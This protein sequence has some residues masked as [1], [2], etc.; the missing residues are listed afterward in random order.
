ME[1]KFL[2]WLFQKLKCQRG[3][4]AEDLNAEDIQ[5]GTFMADID[6]DEY[7]IDQ[8]ENDDKHP[9]EDEADDEKPAED[10]KP[11]E[12]D[13]KIASLEAEIE[14]QQ[15]EINRLGYAIRKQPESDKKD[16][17]DT[18]FTLEQLQKLHKEHHDDPAIVF[19]IMKE[20]TKLGTADATKAAENTAEIRSKQG[21]IDKLVTALYPDAK[22]KESDLYRGVQEAIEWAH[23]QDNPFK[24]TLGLALLFLKDF[25][26]TIEN[27]RSEIKAD[28]EKQT[29]QKLEDKAEAARK[30]SINK[31]KPSRSSKSSDS[32]GSAP[33]LTA[34]QRETAKMMGFTTKKQLAR[35]AKILASKKGT[36]QE[37]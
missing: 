28:F 35:Y 21:E 3:E 2:T 9:E 4:V 14:K 29:G 1:I 6:D 15:K 34:Q 27:V 32:D 22:N 16:D 25:P 24:D 23:L 18:P 7:P 13:T 37:K 20:M 10:D 8:P 12:K 30:E 17:K 31:N 36:H 11:D 33:V 19:E 26:K 5:D